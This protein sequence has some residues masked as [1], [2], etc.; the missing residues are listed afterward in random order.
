[1]TEKLLDALGGVDEKYILP[2]GEKV[3]K[4]RPFRM[5]ALRWAALAA[6]VALILTG[7][8]WFGISVRHRLENNSLASNGEGKEY[9][10]Y[11]RSFDS[12]E[13]MLGGSSAYLET[14]QSRLYALDLEACTA[15]RC[16]YY[17]TSGKT[18]ADIL[19]EGYEVQMRR[20]GVQSFVLWEPYL[21]PLALPERYDAEAWT[22][23][24]TE[25]RGG[26]SIT[27]GRCGGRMIGFINEGR[28]C[29]IL[30][31]YSADAQVFDSLLDDLLS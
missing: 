9:S 30:L 4:K 19:A 23:V 5:T 20:N 21:G 26:V 12:L 31:T 1:M 15:V 28:G 10:Y 25:N 11:S 22:D 24:R 29:Y 14:P 17:G 2:Y 27:C 3:G 18:G 6:A 13:E 7:G 16:R 8:A